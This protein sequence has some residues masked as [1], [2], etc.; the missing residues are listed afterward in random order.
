MYWSSNKF[1]QANIPSCLLI[2]LRLYSFQSSLNFVEET[3]L[4]L[5]ITRFAESETVLVSEDS[6]G[7]DY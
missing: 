2:K 4:C 1:L 6:A 3:S 7:F 5:A